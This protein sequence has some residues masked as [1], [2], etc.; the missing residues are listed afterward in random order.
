VGYVRPRPEEEGIEPGTRSHF[1][2][3]PSVGELMQPS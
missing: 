3:A 1:L 2:R